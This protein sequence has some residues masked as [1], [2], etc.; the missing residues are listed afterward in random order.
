MTHGA[1]LKT[2]LERELPATA[3][4]NWCIYYLDDIIVETVI[5][6]FRP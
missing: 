5:F 2:G 3:S 1:A 6:H 4:N